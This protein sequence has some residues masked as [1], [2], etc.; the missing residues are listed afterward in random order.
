M[1]QTL[2]A[3]WLLAVPLLPLLGSI[4]AGVFGTKL[5]GNLLGRAA[6]HSI[7]IAGVLVSFL[8]SAWTLYLVMQGAH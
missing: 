1:N 4:L 2:N 8:I 3:S 5:G 6:C 7:T